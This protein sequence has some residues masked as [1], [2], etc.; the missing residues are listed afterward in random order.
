M[1]ASELDIAFGSKYVHSDLVVALPK[2]S[3]LDQPL[4]SVVHAS[5]LTK[6][7]GKWRVHQLAKWGLGEA[8]RLIRSNGIYINHERAA[9]SEP[10]SAS[11]VTKGDLLGEGWG[12]IFRAGKANYKVIRVV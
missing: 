11:L 12:L 4:V 5:G 2:D 7:K 6:S 9:A 10:I 3:V 8:T 1:T